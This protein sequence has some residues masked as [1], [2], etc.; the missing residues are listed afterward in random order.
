MPIAIYFRSNINET[1]NNIR[2]INVNP[3]TATFWF[4]DVFILID[5][6]NQPIIMCGAKKISQMGR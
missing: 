4:F 5:R 1:S 3:K 2:V 6:I